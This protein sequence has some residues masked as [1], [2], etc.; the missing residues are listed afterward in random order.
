MKIE[1][2]AI[3][4]GNCSIENGIIKYLEA[5]KNEDG[6]QVRNST[7]IIR[8][9]FSFSNG[10]ICFNVKV[11]DAKS[12]FFLVL[13]TADGREIYI[14]YNRYVDAFIIRYADDTKNEKLLDSAGNLS[15]YQKGEW[16]DIKIKVFGSLISLLANDI[17]MCTANVTLKDR[18]VEIKVSGQH[19]LSIKD[20]T[21]D[22][23]QRKVFVVMQ[24]TQE[25]NDLYNEVILPTIE[26]FDMQCIRA[27]D[28]YSSTPILLDIISE[29]STAS[30]VI[31]DIT[32][33]NPNV[34]YELGYA[35]AIK[36]PTIILAEKQRTKL[37]FDL[38][39]FRTIFYDNS[40]AGKRKVETTL[41]KYIEKITNLTS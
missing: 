27:D 4:Q 19:E 34:F 5:A 37:P 3:I 11:T 32:P 41:R 18:P 17:I 6:K 16:I 13:Q 2:F 20:V 35:H 38:S 40:I 33:D 22:K 29:L 39:G 14:G 10:I 26:K 23:E 24:F 30:I 21:I 28:I 25:Y 12:S 31:A 7:A 1:K 15:N 36:K 8:S 9:S